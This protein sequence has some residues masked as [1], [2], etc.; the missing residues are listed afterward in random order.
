MQNYAVVLP[1]AN[2]PVCWSLG[3][4][5]QAHFHFCLGTSQTHRVQ[6]QIWLQALM[7]W[8][9]W[10][11]QLLYL[12]HPEEIKEWLQMRAWG[13]TELQSWF[14]ATTGHGLTNFLLFRQMNVQILVWSPFNDFRAFTLHFIHSQITQDPRS[15]QTLHIKTNGGPYYFP[16]AFFTHRVAR[17][18]DL[19][20]EMAYFLHISWLTSGELAVLGLQGG[21]LN[22]IKSFWKEHLWTSICCGG[23]W[24]GVCISFVPSES[25][26]QILQNE[27][28]SSSFQEGATA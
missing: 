14:R 27:Q 21:R 19:A 6:I 8:S 2:S 16:S 5:H 13:M 18:L 10:T 7:A 26:V 25:W 1:K 12:K 28:N 17:I 4:D 22:F 3:S 20:S 23:W 15:A 11:P 24:A 9:W